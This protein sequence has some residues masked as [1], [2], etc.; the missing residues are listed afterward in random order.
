M[1]K[2]L[3][4]NIKMIENGVMDK[5]LYGEI[6]TGVSKQMTNMYTLE[7]CIGKGWAALPQTSMHWVGQRINNGFIFR[8]LTPFALI[9]C[10]NSFAHSAFVVGLG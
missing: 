7:C 4:G 10:Y 1:Q 9:R 6:E 8:L 5:K 2:D 3:R